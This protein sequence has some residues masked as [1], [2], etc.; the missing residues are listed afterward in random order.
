MACHDRLCLS[1]ATTQAS[2]LCHSTHVVLCNPRV[3]SW[4]G[5]QKGPYGALCVTFPG[6]QNNINDLKDYNMEDICNHCGI[7]Q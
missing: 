6:L 2:F 5:P 1:S 3:W 4:Q 7:E